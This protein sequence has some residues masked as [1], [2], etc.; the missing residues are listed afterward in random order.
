[1]GKMA[2]MTAKDGDIKVEW[3]N[4]K[5]EEVTHAR[6]TFRKMKQKGYAAYRTNP[7]GS[8][9]E[10]IREFDPAAESIVMAP[11]MVGG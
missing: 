10:L 11:Q 8:K 2:V 1:M 9:G 5:P 7:K 6:E 4:D 3:D